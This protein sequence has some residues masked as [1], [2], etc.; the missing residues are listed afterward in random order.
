M[1]GNPIANKYC[2]GKMRRTLERECTRLEIVE[3]EAVEFHYSMIIKL[4]Q[5]QLVM[6]TLNM[7]GEVWVARAV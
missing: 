4:T 1:N 3:K 6:H 2:E 7:Q 5:N